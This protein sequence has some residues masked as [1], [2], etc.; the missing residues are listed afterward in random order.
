MVDAAAA[1]TLAER[2][3]SAPSSNPRRRGR[4]ADD[5]LRVAT[6]RTDLRQARTTA[7]AWTRPRGRALR[8]ARVARRKRRVVGFVSEDDLR[9][10]L[11]S[12]RRRERLGGTHRRTLVRGVSVAARTRR[13]ALV[14]LGTPPPPDDSSR[15]RRKSKSKLPP[16]DRRK[17]RTTLGGSR[18]LGRHR[19]RRDDGG[20][21]DW[22][23]GVSSAARRRWP[24]PTVNELKAIKVDNR[25]T[26]VARRCSRLVSRP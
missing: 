26:R 12:T 10:L 25:G 16:S 13:D 18:S 15:R 7:R 20:F 8:A 23:L 3:A 11:A 19:G 4:L 9:S 24:P 6:A 14:A 2:S 22:A 21:R 17:P 1:R 5:L